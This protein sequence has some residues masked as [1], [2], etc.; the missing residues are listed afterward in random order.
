MLN[1]RLSPD[2]NFTENRSETQMHNSIYA[3]AYAP[4][5]ESGKIK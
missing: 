4:P 2:P 3:E 5:V 1:P